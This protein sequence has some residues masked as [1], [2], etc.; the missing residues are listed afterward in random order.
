MLRT[1][2]SS[3]SLRD[4]VSPGNQAE[5][6]AERRHDLARGR[7]LRDSGTV[8]SL[9]R[10][11]PCATPAG[12]WAESIWSTA[13]AEPFWLPSILS[14][15]PPTPTAAAPSVEPDGTDVPPDAG[16]A[17]DRRAAA[18]LEED[19][20]GVFRHGTA[21][22]V[23]AQDTTVPD[24]EKPHEH[25]ETAGAVGAEMEPVLTRAAQRRTAGDPH[26]R[27]LR[28]ARRTAGPG[29]RLRADH[30][31]VGHRQVGGAADRRRAAVG[32]AGRHGRRDRTAPVEK[33]RLLSRA[34]RHLRGEAHAVAIAGADSR[35]SAS[36]G[37]PTWPPHGSGRCSWSTK[38][39]R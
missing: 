16:R 2:P 23:P 21:A 24:T 32:A 14:T 5:S 28:L 8:P 20:P 12:T 33:R 18:A 19:P 30:G 27:A 39:R 3:E 11:R 37:R 25:Q 26:D 22:G 1:S 29:G 7:A 4:G 6:A 31:R 36:A 13:A 10:S 38:P 34:G 17:Q 9:P 35:R 15:R